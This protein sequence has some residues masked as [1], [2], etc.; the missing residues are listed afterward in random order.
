MPHRG[1]GLPAGMGGETAPQEPDAVGQSQTPLPP[2]LTRPPDR[3]HQNRHCPRPPGPASRASGPATPSVQVDCPRP[4]V[5]RSEWKVP[6]GGA[7]G[8]GGPFPRG[9]RGRL[10]QTWGFDEW[11]LHRGQG[12]EE[13]PRK[14]GRWTWNPAA[15]GGAVHQAAPVSPP[16]GRFLARESERV[17]GQRPQERASL[18]CA[19][20]QPRA[21]TCADSHP[22]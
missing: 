16:W 17:G 11:G 15:A 8:L 2:G 13:G 21:P 7:P 20:G 3:P 9:C 18:P 4:E 22:S 12:R 10:L 1:H 6:C 19:Q 5:I 14:M